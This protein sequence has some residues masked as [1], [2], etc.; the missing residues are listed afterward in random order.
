MAK[1]DYYDVLGVKRNASAD[2]IRAAFRALARKYHPDVNKAPDAEAKFREASEAYEALS[3]PEKRKIYDRF[4]HQGPGPGPRGGGGHPG[5][6]G[7]PVDFGDLFGGL[8]G[9]F[10]GMSLKDILNSLRDRASGGRARRR[11]ARGADSESHLTLDFMQTVRGTATRLRIRRPGPDGAPH[12]ETI[13]VKIPPGVQEGSKVRVRGKGQA[14]GREAGDLYILVH[15]RPHPYF[16]R[17]GDDIQVTVPISIAEAALGAKVDVPTLDGLTTVTIPPGTA[18]SQRLR[19]RGKGVR[20]PGKE[21]GD[22]YVEIDIIPPKDP[23]PQQR[24]CL[25]RL[26]EISKDDPRSR[27]PWT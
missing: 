23:T 12:E 9:G 3:D 13:E 1:R 15:V 20:R 21:P 14:G 19:L 4:G 6:A 8:G 26:A 17:E 2:E 10:A 7:V 18:S 11:P 16:R 22:L 24:E 5:G 27:C 25:Q